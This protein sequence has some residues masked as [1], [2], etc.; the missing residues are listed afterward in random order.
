MAVL[1]SH[2]DL[3]ELLC[4]KGATVNAKNNVGFCLG[5][6]YCISMGL[7]IVIGSAVTIIA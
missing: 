1:R 4:D 3:V 7:F 5:S 2:K 6:V